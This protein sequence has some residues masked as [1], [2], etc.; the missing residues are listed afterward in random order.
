MTRLKFSGAYVGL[1]VRGKTNETHEP[2]IMAQHADCILSNG[3][4]VGFF[5]EGRSGSSGSSASSGVNMKG[6][7]YDMDKLAQNRPY[8][9][10]GALAKGYGVVS[11]VLAIHV[12]E[13][14]A[15]LFDAAWAATAV[16]PPVFW[17][18][19]ANCSTRAAGVFKSAGILVGGIPG[20]DTPNNLFKQLA[21]I[22]SAKSW[23]YYGYVG[24]EKT[25][26]GHEVTIENVSV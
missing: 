26:S 13:V 22:Y 21:T 23:S 14:A 9:T 7:V 4:C 15:K 6:S 20:L 17:L 19:G 8:Y 25:N 18:A 1:I 3:S 11:G 2:G 16:D 24:F 10:D 5:G 12:G